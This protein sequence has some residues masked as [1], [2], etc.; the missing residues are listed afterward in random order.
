M[1]ADED[2]NHPINKTPLKGL[3]PAYFRAATPL[4]E[5]GDLKIG[6]RPSRRQVVVLRKTDGSDE[7]IRPDSVPGIETL[8]AIP[9]VFAWYVSL[10]QSCVAPISHLLGAGPKLDCTYPFGSGESGFHILIDFIPDL[11]F[12]S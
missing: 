4:N 8:R 7:D 11:V 2:C 3:F 12:R 1:Y 10:I 9:W 6:S 5:L